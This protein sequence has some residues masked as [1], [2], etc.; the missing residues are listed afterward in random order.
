[1]LAPCYRVNASDL[2]CTSACLAGSVC[3][4]LGVAGRGAPGAGP[5]CAVGWGRSQDL[6]TQDNVS[7]NNRA[8]VLCKRWAFPFPYA[9]GKHLAEHLVDSYRQKYG[10]PLA[11]VRPRYPPGA[12]AQQELARASCRGATHPPTHTHSPSPAHQ[13]TPP[14]CLPPPPPVRPAAVL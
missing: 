2:Q 4:H 5:Q 3:R 13:P 14:H 7:S 10:L 12:P 8:R 1:M 9:L 11:I 6:L